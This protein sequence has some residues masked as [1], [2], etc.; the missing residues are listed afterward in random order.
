M[1]HFLK[2]EVLPLLCCIR[3][4]CDQ[5]RLYTANHATCLGLGGCNCNFMVGHMA[6]GKAPIWHG[7]AVS[8]CSGKNYFF[9][10]PGNFV[11]H[12]DAPPTSGK[13]KRAVVEEV[14]EGDRVALW[15]VARFC[16]ALD[17]SPF[18]GSARN[19]MERG[20]AEEFEGDGFSDEPAPARIVNCDGA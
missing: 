1:Y 5:V 3:N 6:C 8:A 2:M 15:H 11:L 18:K 17:H 20:G 4:R 19:N 12:E 16:L 13:G 9:S 14:V 7:T 10:V